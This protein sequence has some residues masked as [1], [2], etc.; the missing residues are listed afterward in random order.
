MW[1]KTRC[2]SPHGAVS[3]C[4]LLPQFVNEDNEIGVML[5]ANV[6]GPTHVV[7]ARDAELLVRLMVVVYALDSRSEFTVDPFDFSLESGK[8]LTPF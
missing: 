5:P 1:F 4:L 7:V 3:Q 6:Y 8:R 2:T